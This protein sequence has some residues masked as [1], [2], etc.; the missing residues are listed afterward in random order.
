MSIS[1]DLNGVEFILTYVYKCLLMINLVS[2]LHASISDY[3]CLYTEFHASSIISHPRS[4]YA[5]WCWNN[6][7][8]PRFDS[9][10]NVILI[11]FHLAVPP[12]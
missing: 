3:L 1:S 2:E 9:G 11:R 7:A 6:T 10:G 5:L 8:D 12:G 4:D